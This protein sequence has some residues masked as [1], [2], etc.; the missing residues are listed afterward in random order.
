V[1]RLFGLVIGTAKAHRKEITDSFDIGRARGRVAIKA[2]LGMLAVDDL[3]R[4]WAEGRHPRL[5]RGQ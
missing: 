1:I 3:D 5:A 4:L 2:E